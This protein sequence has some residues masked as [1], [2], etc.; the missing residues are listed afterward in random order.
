MVLYI[1]TSTLLDFKNILHKKRLIYLSITKCYVYSFY[2]IIKFVTILSSICYI[3]YVI[4][5]NLVCISIILLKL[6]NYAF[7]VNVSV[8]MLIFLK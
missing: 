5:F 3:D 8:S 2:N 6:F 1:T 4:F 7:L